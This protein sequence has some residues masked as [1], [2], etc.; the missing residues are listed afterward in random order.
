MV[1]QNERS[2][3]GVDRRDPDQQTWPRVPSPSGVNGA[4]HADR[5][6]THQ[7]GRCADRMV[8][9][10]R[11]R[12]CFSVKRLVHQSVGSGRSSRS[13]CA[14][15]Q[16]LF[17]AHFSASWREGTSRLA[18]FPTSRRSLH[19]STGLGPRA[20]TDP[21]SRRSSPCHRLRAG[22]SALIWRAL[23]LRW[24]LRLR[25]ARDAHRVRCRR[26]PPRPGA[27]MVHRVARVR[28]GGAVTVPCE[29][30]SPCPRGGGQGP[31]HKGASRTPAAVSSR[32]R[33]PARRG[34]GSGARAGRC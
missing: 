27:Q 23:S 9:P 22:P 5:R 29:S 25:D 2:P 1:R 20:C 30:A 26:T 28:R 14:Q 4:T 3:C 24:Q 12:F 32:F 33:C 6:V 18:Q 10:R 17:A 21:W 8:R 11:R 13:C 15:R 16:R 31:V 19:T 34:G 7:S